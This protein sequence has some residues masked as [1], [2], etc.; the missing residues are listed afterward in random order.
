MII[1]Y[2]DIYSLLSERDN[3]E[4]MEINEWAIVE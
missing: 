1:G 4:M 2:I 3:K